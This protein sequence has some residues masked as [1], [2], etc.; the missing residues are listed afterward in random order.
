MLIYSIAS[1]LNGHSNGEAVMHLI[2]RFSV[3]LKLWW[4]H[5]LTNEQK[6][7]IKNHRTRVKR[8]IKVEV[9]ATETPEVEE[10]VEDAVDVLLCTINRHFSLG[11]DIDIYN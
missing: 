6:E 7:A 4:D 8:T 2:N 11:S 9:G 10:E 3:S 5:S 1:E